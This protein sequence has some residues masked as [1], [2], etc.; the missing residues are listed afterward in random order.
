[1]TAPDGA[2]MEGGV[3]V[4]VKRRRNV[5]ARAEGRPNGGLVSG[6]LPARTVT[7][8]ADGVSKIEEA[9]GRAGRD[10]SIVAHI[11]GVD[12]S[13]RLTGWA[14][15]PDHPRRRVAVSAYID[16]EL[17]SFATANL[18][19]G[20]VEKAGF[21]DGLYGF[22]LPLPEHVFDGQT[23][24]FSLQFEAS[25]AE[26]FTADIERKM[27][28]RSASDAGGPTGSDASAADQTDPE[29][30]KPAPVT[31][32]AAPSDRQATA[33]KPAADEVISGPISRPFR[34]NIDEITD[35]EI[36]GWI[37]DSAQVSRRCTVALREGDRLVSR[38]VA[39]VFRQ[40]LQS[41]EIGDGCHAFALPMPR[42]LLDGNDHRLDIIELMSVLP[43]NDE[44]ILWR[45]G[46]GTGGAALTT[47]E[48]SPELETEALEPEAPVE[49]RALRSNG[50]VLG[51][52]SLELDRPV[53]RQVA[54]GT[55]I[56]FDVSD[57]VYY[58]GHHPNLTGIQRVQSSIVLAI[59]M[60][61][62]VPVSDLVF[63]S[64]N[65]RSR[66]WVA[67]PTGFLSSVLEDLFLPQE[68]RLVRFPA[69]EARYGML[70][71]ARELEG[72]GLVDGATPSVLCLLGA[73]WV[74]RDYFHRVLM[75]KRRYGTRFVMTVHDLIPIYARE[76]CDQGTARV[77]EEFL[78]RAL[79]HTDHFLSVSDNTAKDLKRYARALSRP[80]PPITVTRNGSSFEEFLPQGGP[81]NEAG[82]ENLPDRFVLFV[83]TIEGRKNHRLV[84]DIWRRMIEAGE[85]PPCLVCVGR[86]GWKSE[87]FIADLVETS[88]L[89]GKV[90]LLQDVSDAQLK[91]MYARTL[92]TLCPS[93][94]EG[95]GLPVGESLAAGKICVCSDRASL[96]EVAGEF[97]VY[98]DIDDLDA[99]V[100]TVSGLVADAARRKRLEHKIRRGYRPTTWRSVA[101]AV[102]GAC[103]ATAGKEWPAPYPH[104]AVPYST[105]ISFAWLGR[106]AQGSFGDDLLAQIVDA[107]RGHFLNE[108]LQ[109]Q[110][111]LRG[112]EVRAAGNWGEPEHWGTW[113]CQ[114]GGEI[115]LG[116]GPNECSLYYVFLR[117]RAPGPLSE[118]PIRISAN[119]EALWS[120]LLGPR[121]KDVHFAV[122]RR[123][124]GP[125]GWRLRLR[126]E[127]DLPPELHAEIAAMDGRVPVIGLERLVV[128]PEDDLKTRLDVLYTLML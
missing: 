59:V 31:K 72:S 34:C 105:E 97:G 40:D 61:E 113:L 13:G 87:S 83:A 2:N 122:R 93:L 5:T 79:R 108:P 114:G 48:P 104:A 30:E 55:R 84:F 90:I 65:A 52:A 118:L 45:S 126:L 57:L 19:R 71:G 46:A 8:P 43:L 44:P 16:T 100:A 91:L 3:D 14:W 41:A 50:A 10:A 1:M 36:S 86:V 111:F 27:P 63:V 53:A 94:Y 88:Y 58:L 127:V 51:A 96:P 73:A 125:D 123:A 60:N 107:R 21:G 116:L 35:S 66:K 99:A 128:V 103:R 32:A 38:A 115:V 89:G 85:D 33:E 29:I 25:G 75:F 102:I 109:E 70:P 119:G 42:S 64:F 81:V 77:F 11:D 12:E 82:S 20:D 110:S 62:L 98:L 6:P 26:T 7:E 47:M 117:L 101:E 92:F 124:A 54:A 95:W 78:R 18:M 76:T 68:Q 23:W 80:E 28:K 69:E 4:A 22:L 17:V 9:Q 39:S 37:H 106:E 121:P 74:Q 120:G 56:M 24:R 15:V 49:M 112:E 67:I